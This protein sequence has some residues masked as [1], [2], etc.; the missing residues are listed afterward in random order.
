MSKRANP[1]FV[2][3]VDFGASTGA[4]TVAFGQASRRVRRDDSAEFAIEDLT[5]ALNEIEEANKGDDASALGEH[6]RVPSDPSAYEVSAETGL[7]LL[8]IRPQE[9]KTSPIS[10]EAVNEMRQTVLRQAVSAMFRERQAEPLVY[11]RDVQLG[12]ALTVDQTP[13]TMAK[14]LREERREALTKLAEEIATSTDPVQLADW[15]DAVLEAGAGV[16]QVTALA[17]VH[18]PAT[19]QNS[20]RLLLG[21]PQLSPDVA[22]GIAKSHLVAPFVLEVLSQSQSERV[23]QAV[24]EN[25]NTKSSTRRQLRKTVSATSGTAAAK[26]VAAPRHPSLKV[27]VA[28]GVAAVLIGIVIAVILSGNRSK[29]DA[30]ANSGYPEVSREEWKVL[31]AKPAQHAGK[32]VAFLVH[33]LVSEGRGRGSVGIVGYALPA[34]PDNWPSVRNWLGNGSMPKDRL[35]LVDAPRSASSGIQ[36]EDVVR[37]QGEL[38]GARRLE[39]RNDLTVKVPFFRAHAIEGPS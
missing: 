34:Q 15:T 18:N 32:Q 27:W 25:A 36:P 14:Q 6:F 23:R 35:V 20:L 29:P 1:F 5:A 30:S 28:L 37:G 22:V 12:V 3:G 11:G 39:S 7:L 13:E 24:G 21:S 31:A 2:L 19:P 33:V 26:R 16:P 8:P 10:D 17:L 4:A 9:R 38:I